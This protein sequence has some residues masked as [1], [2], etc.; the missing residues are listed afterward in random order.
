MMT[1]RRSTVDVEIAV[2]DPM[3]SPQQRNGVGEPVLRII[4][5][6]ERD[7]AKQQRQP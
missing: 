5:E 1:E 4:G 6:I 7:D 3:K 2:M